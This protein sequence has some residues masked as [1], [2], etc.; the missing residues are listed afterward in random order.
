MNEGLFVVYVGRSRFHTECA[1]CA[2]TCSE[3]FPDGAYR[4]AYR[5]VLAV[6]LNQ[7]SNTAKCKHCSMISPE[8]CTS[9]NRTFRGS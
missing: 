5:T 3:A 9:K 1:V 4:T 2:H 6:S 7:G 8:G